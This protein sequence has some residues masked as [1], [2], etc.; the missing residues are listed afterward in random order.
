MMKN[1][2]RLKEGTKGEEVGVP[3]TVVLGSR[4]RD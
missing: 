2:P 1:W 4:G 3:S